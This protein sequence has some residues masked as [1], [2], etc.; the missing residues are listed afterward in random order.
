M[1]KNEFCNAL[2][3]KHYGWHWMLMGTGIYWMSTML[4][5]WYNPLFFLSLFTLGVGIFWLVYPPKDDD[6]AEE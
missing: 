5:P 1:N 6:D 4:P 3:G 2:L